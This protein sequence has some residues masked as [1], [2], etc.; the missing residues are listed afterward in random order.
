[1]PLMESSLTLPRANSQV[2]VRV[3]LSEGTVRQARADPDSTISPESTG[4]TATLAAPPRPAW[5]ALHWSLSCPGHSITN[6]ISSFTDSPPLLD[7]ITEQ[8]DVGEGQRTSGL[9]A[10]LHLFIFLCFISVPHQTVV[11][12][13]L[14]T[15]RGRGPVGQGQPRRASWGRCHL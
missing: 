4:P 6:C 10:C 1:M 8:S 14:K 5:S 9:R 11:V 15:H 13:K 3:L 12:E 2:L 7:S